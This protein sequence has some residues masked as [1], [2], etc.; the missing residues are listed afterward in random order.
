MQKEIEFKEHGNI[1]SSFDYFQKFEISKDAKILDVG[2]YFGSLIYQIYQQ[3]YKN[4]YGIDVRDHAVQAGKQQYP[5]LA[6]NITFYEGDVL[7]YDEGTFDVVM[8]FDVI[9]HIPEVED[10][11]ATQ[12]F[13]VLKPGGKFIFQTPNKITNIPWEIVNKR[14]FTAYKAYHCSLQTRGSLRQMLEKVG[15]SQITIEKHNIITD[16]NQN[17]LQE[18]I[19]FVA[20]PLLFALQQMP[21]AITPNFWGSCVK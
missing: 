14:S 10:F 4:V 2:C 15:F 20:R 21:L 5:I 9:E 17:R 18:K 8:M 11:L 19:G 13:R 12:V 16:Y 3:G 7:P 6:E 1:K